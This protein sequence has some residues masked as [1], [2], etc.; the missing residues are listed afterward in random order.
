MK[1]AGKVGLITGA[2]SGIGRAIARCFA[3]EGASVAVLD[4][5][6]QAAD[7]VAADLRS[8]GTPALGLAADVSQA[9][10]VE[11][12]VEECVRAFGRLD[13]LVNNAGILGRL[14]RIIDSTD[15]AWDRVFAV[16]VRG[17]FLCAKY[18]MPHLAQRGGVIVNIASTAGLAASALLGA[19]G[20]SKA[21][22]I[23][24]T[25]SLALNHA[26]EGVRV[27]CVCPGSVET[28][29]LETVFAW[30]P[31]PEAQA[32]LR[33]QY[34]LRHPIGRFGQPDEVARAALFLASDDASFVTGA[35]LPVDGGRLA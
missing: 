34:L 27:N 22:L 17:A 19:Y 14:G 32:A 11:D 16:N 18:A 3:S 23:Q 10:Q 8:G 5:D 2:G 26:G 28:R 7:A 31:N 9:K 6:R 12:A 25:R 1:L 15:D 13:I 24:M 20:A 35:V 33:R 30:P 21:A 4:V 29:M